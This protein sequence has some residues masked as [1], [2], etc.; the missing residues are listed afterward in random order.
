M[1]VSHQIMIDEHLGLLA[2]SEKKSNNRLCSAFKNEMRKLAEKEKKTKM[3]KITN[4]IS[5]WNN[6][7]NIEKTWMKCGE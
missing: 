3:V 6:K 2:E 5:F 4:L 1:I 7:K